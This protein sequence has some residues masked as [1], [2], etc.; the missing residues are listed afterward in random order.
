MQRPCVL[1]YVVTGEV[2]EGISI[3]DHYC[4]GLAESYAD[5]KRYNSIDNAAYCSTQVKFT[6]L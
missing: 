6:G 4:V 1:F 5:L 3:S 2:A